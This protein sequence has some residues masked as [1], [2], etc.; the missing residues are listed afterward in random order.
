MKEKLK[1]IVFKITN[2]KKLSENIIR[3][4]S[5][6]IIILVLL[7]FIYSHNI[8]FDICF[9]FTIGNFMSMEWGVIVG[10][11]EH[12]NKWLII[13][14]IYI[15]IT[16]LPLFILKTM[17]DGSNLLMWLF[18]LV[19]CTDTFAYIVGKTLNLGKHKISSISPKKSYE[20]LIGGIL[21]S[22]IICYLFSYKFLPEYKSLLLYFTPL[23]CCLE[24]VGDFTES[25][26]KRKFNVKDSGDMI[27]G[28]GGFLD[29]FDG[30]LYIAILLIYTLQFS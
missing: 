15:T 14:S 6:I 29:R 12:K 16:L 2:N 9:L 20:G 3:S 17:P 8:F 7:V 26:V 23:F 5:G 11:S 10:N 24:Q 25:Y 1:N 21:G 22:I 19:W 4:V 18:L 30:F 28:H 27:P 13:G